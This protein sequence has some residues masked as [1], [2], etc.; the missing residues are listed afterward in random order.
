MMQHA[1]SGSMGKEAT[2]INGLVEEYLRLAFHG[3]RAKGQ[4]IQCKS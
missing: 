3:T 1:G 2:D 4:V